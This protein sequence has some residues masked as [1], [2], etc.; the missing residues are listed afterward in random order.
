M[1]DKKNS[2]ISKADEVKVDK[3]NDSLSEDSAQLPVV[4]NKKIKVLAKKAKETEEKQA[5]EKEELKI[6]KIVPVKNTVLFP[7]NVV[8]F[9]AG[10]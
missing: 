6:L 1:E 7:H 10:K 5:E 8:P 4:I 3:Q 9:T 2:K